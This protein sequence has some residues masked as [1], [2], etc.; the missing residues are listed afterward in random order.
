MQ[1]VIV[2]R[3]ILNLVQGADNREDTE[4]RTQTGL[5]PPVFATGPFLGD[6]GGPL[7]TLPDNMDD[8]LYEGDEVDND[9]DSTVLP[10]D[11]ITGGLTAAGAIGS[12]T[13]LGIMDCVKIG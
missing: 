2:N 11:E 13:S 1:A 6:I 5:E 8:E 3:L 4:L 10:N 9:S 12:G 7:R